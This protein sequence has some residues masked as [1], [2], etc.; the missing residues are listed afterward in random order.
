MALILMQLRH[1]R[2]GNLAEGLQ[3]ALCREAHHIAGYCLATCLRPRQ[4][5]A[6]QKLQQGQYSQARHRQI[7]QTDHA[8]ILL[9]T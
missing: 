6:D 3:Q 1:H 7:D 9:K 5:A 8:L 2:Q 4:V